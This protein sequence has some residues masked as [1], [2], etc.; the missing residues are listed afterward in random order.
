MRSSNKSEEHL[1]LCTMEVVSFYF[2]VE[3]NPNITV[4]G[5]DGGDGYFCDQD[6][7]HVVMR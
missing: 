7:K 3:G 2:W 6:P 5:W 1:P 4:E